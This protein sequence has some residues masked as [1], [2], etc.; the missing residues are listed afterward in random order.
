M[1]GF[2]NRIASFKW[3]FNGL[4]IF[5]IEEFNAK[6]HFVAAAT[7]L[8]L[9]FFFKINKYEWMAVLFAI[10]MV[11]SAELI[12]TAIEHLADVVS[13]EKK[14]AIKKVKDMAAAAV[15]I[16]AFAALLIGVFIFLPKFVAH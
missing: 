1:S 6:V 4:R 9:G 12:N 14:P 15:L 8:I 5:F 16:V 10:A 11:I 7:V 13:P 2:K 3:A